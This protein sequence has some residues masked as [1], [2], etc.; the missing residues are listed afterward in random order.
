MTRFWRDIEQGINIV[1]KSFSRMI[2]GEIF[3]T[4]KPSIKIT[5]FA[6]EMEQN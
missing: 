5:D 3:I 2:G 4:I 1:E 6:K